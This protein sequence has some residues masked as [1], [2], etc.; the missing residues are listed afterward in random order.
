M[1]IESK[2]QCIL[3]KTFEMDRGKSR[4]RLENCAAMVGGCNS[5]KELSAGGIRDGRSIRGLRNNMLGGSFV[6]LL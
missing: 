3:R 5:L 4:K 6:K 1:G 2:W